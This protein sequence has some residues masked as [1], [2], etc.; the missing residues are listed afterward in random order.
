MLATR[1]AS[2]PQASEEKA[3]T[4]ATAALPCKNFLRCMFIDLF[5]SFAETSS[6]QVFLQDGR[7]N[8]VLRIEHI[9]ETDTPGL[10]EQHVGVDLVKAV[11]GTY[12]AQSSWRRFGSPLA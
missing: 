12:P 6:D 7:A 11:I 2:S 8:R 3:P 10:T 9:T 1:I 5:P 4:A